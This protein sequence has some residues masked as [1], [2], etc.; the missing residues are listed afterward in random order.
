MNSTELTFKTF[1][2]LAILISSLA[3]SM[4]CASMCGGLVTLVSRNKIS[5]CF[6]HLGRLLG[7][8]GLGAISGLLGEKLLNSKW[9]I[10]I[11][12]LSACLLALSFFYLA[13]R[14][15]RGENHFF[16][17]PAF[18]AKF[19]QASAARFFSPEQKNSFFIY[20][21]GVTGLLS[22]F[23]PCAWLYSFVLGAIATQSLIYGALFLF[24]FWLG[25]LPAMSLTPYLLQTLFI[26]LQKKS[27]KISA[28]LLLGIGLFTLAV[29]L[30]P[31]MGS[32][33]HP[34]MP[35]CNLHH[36]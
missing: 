32:N 22:V 16:K 13:F 6:Y 31:L 4:H 11:A 9:N 30:L 33:S 10:Y 20:E 24:I 29:K 36:H 14:S 34:H 19:Y 21:A 5:L 15:W 12:L 18:L 1:V 35:F 28:L 27:P 3:G 25:T 17:M 23:L 8:L 26:P 2:P 7:Y